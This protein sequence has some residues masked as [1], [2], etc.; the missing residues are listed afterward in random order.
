[1]A[2]DLNKLKEFVSSD[3]KMLFD[4]CFDE[5]VVRFDMSYRRAEKRDYYIQTYNKF[6][7]DYRNILNVL[8]FDHASESGLIE[9]C[10]KCK[11]EAS[12]LLDIVFEY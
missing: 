3:E 1:M 11:K 9:K 12:R 6:I 5:K 10:T 4:G 7:D 2:V 8:K